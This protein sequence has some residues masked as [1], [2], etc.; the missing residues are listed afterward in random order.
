MY[1]ILKLWTKSLL[2]R[3]RLSMN[4]TWWFFLWCSCSV[5]LNADSAEPHS[6]SGV[7]IDRKEL[8]SL[9]PR[10]LSTRFIPC[11]KEKAKIV[12]R[13]R[14]KNTGRTDSEFAGSSLFCDVS[15]GNWLRGCINDFCLLP[16][17]LCLR[18]QLPACWTATLWGAGTL[19]NCPDCK[20]VQYKDHTER[21]NSQ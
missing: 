17:E 6:L 12:R 2:H 10:L 16:Q 19:R 1:L 13:G 20:A 21:L 3:R 8:T 11:E 9:D 7:C 18:V 5:N 15:C 4:R 14:A